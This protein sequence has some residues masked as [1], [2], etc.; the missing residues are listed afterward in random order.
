LEALEDERKRAED[1]RRRRQAVEDGERRRWEEDKQRLILLTERLE[2]EVNR[3]KELEARLN[4]LK[5]QR[6]KEAGMGLR[7]KDL[8]MSG[9][10]SHFFKTKNPFQ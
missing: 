8:G 5:A 2:E 4:S 3:R 6:E 9:I 1:E 10:I 7:M